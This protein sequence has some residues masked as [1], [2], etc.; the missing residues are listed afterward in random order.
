MK[1]GRSKVRMDKV[2]QTKGYERQSNIG[3]I[4]VIERNVMV[5]RE[6]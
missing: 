1:G 6:R 4:E 2:R 3:N 5:I